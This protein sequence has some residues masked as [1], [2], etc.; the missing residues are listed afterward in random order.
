L[1]D[2]KTIQSALKADA[3]Y[4]RA[5][6]DL[7]QRLRVSLRRQA[8]PPKRFFLRPLVATACLLLCVGLGM[9]LGRA[10]L[11]GSARERLLQQVT[12]S[13]IRSLQW[14]HLM[15]VPSSNQHV[16]KP[17]FTGKLDFSPTVRIPAPEEFPL[18]GGRLDYMD[19]RPVA[20]LVYKRREHVINVFMWPA[21]SSDDLAPQTET[22]QGFQIIHWSKAGMN[23]WV[24]SDL[25]AT[26]LDEFARRLR[27]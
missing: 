10:D 23:F 1:A 18:E 2:E 12:A 5:P 3:L 11:S 13:H 20:A 14:N 16:V 22:R 15:D 26:E 4:Y 8:R 6:D 24:V 21:P 19:G 25:N 27:E 7:H 17:W 9:L